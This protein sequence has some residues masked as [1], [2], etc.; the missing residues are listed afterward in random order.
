MYSGTLPVNRD[1]FI[2]SSVLPKGITSLSSIGGTGPERLIE[3]P[4]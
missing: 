1:R 2:M 3:G 4:N